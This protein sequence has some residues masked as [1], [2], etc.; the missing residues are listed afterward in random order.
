MKSSRIGIGICLFLILI[1]FF[2][3]KKRMI[4]NSQ[5]ESWLLLV[6]KNLSLNEENR[7]KSKYSSA[8]LNSHD[9]LFNRHFFRLRNDKMYYNSKQNE[10]DKKRKVCNQCMNTTQ[11]IKEYTTQDVVR[12]LDVR[13]A[14]KNRRPTH[15][16]FIGDSTVRQY[17]LSFL[18]VSSQ[19]LYFF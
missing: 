14:Q 3:A 1:C 2:I 4:L 7:A 19:I 5:H 17:F 9:Y 6:K 18:R 10:E 13:S 16:A 12:C 15:I 8:W 11:L